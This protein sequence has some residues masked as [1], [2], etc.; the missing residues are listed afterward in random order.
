MYPKKIIREIKNTSFVGLYRTNNFLPNNWEEKTEWK[1]GRETYRSWKPSKS[2]Q[3]Q[4]W[5]FILEQGERMWKN[6]N[7]WECG[8]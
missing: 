1:M 3:L 4:S 2:I 7:E 8:R 6:M 5:M